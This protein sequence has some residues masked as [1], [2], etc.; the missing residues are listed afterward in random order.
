MLLDGVDGANVCERHIASSS[1]SSVVALTLK[2]VFGFTELAS[3]GRHTGSGTNTQRVDTLCLPI[4]T[5]E[6]YLYIVFKS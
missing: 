6:V 1:S 3:Q 5:Y 2:K 4:N